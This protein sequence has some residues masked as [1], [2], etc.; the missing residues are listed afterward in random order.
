MA[1]VN[2]E[3]RKIAHQALVTLG[4]MNYLALSEY[5]RIIRVAAEG[6]TDKELIA[7]RKRINA[8]KA[9]T[10]DMMKF[11]DHVFDSIKRR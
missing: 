2:W 9:A 5:E 11:R 7:F 1:K 4:P 10:E 3:R 6:F 8:Y